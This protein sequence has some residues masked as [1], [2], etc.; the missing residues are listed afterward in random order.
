M[1]L[2]Y[3]SHFVSAPVPASWH[4]FSTHCASLPGRPLLL[5]PVLCPGAGSG[6]LGA[7]APA[8]SLCLPVNLRSR[9]CCFFPS[10]PYRAHTALCTL[11]RAPRC[12]QRQN[13]FGCTKHCCSFV[14]LARHRLFFPLYSTPCSLHWMLICLQPVGAISFQTASVSSSC[15]PLLLPIPVISCTVQGLQSCCV[16][17]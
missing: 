14:A 15:P 7:A 3:W 6:L 8:A 4:L 10:I 12:G 16:A 5:W 17:C 9:A 11:C 1:V 13:R 2:S